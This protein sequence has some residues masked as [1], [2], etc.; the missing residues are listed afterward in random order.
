MTCNLLII[1]HK[2]GALCGYLGDTAGNVV[3]RHEN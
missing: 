1:S 2:D 3:N